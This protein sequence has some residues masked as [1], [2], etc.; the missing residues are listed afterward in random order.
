MPSPS[1][2]K[3]IAVVEWNWTGHHPAYFNNFVL[4]LEELGFD[5]LAICPDLT[6]LAGNI[7]SNPGTDMACHGKTQYKQIAISSATF[8]L[9][10]S[11]GI[12][13]I[14]WT[15]RFFR[16]IEQQVREWT[17]ESGRTVA[18]IFYCCMYDWEFAWAHLAQPFLT[19]PW[20]G[21]YL[22]A[23][24]YRMPNTVNP[25][26]R[27]VPR[28]EIMFGG[29]LCKG[30]AILDEGICKEVSHSTGKPVVAL[31]DVTDERLVVNSEGKRLGEQL[32]SFAAGRPVVGLFGHLGSSK[33]VRTFLAG[34]KIADPSKVCFALG[35]EKG[36]SGEEDREVK[37]LLDESP[38]VW[39]HLNRISDAHLNH[40]M[41][42]CQ[43][44]YAAYL[45]FPHSSNIMTKA[46]LL[47][48]PLVV[49]D[50]YLMAERTRRFNLGEIIPQ[51]NCEAFLGAIEKITKDLDAWTA[52][53]KPRW[54]DYRCEH[55]FARL[56][57]SLKE[58]FDHVR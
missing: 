37:R 14:Y 42:K 8:R 38:N 47:E 16:S 49:S 20:T 44:V 6:E 2:K 52:R 3:T 9:N 27:K 18:G 43:V 46:A 28:P 55:S 26:T 33:G 13:T 5:V 19:I 22:Q 35:G 31:P 58:L 48:K 1:A 15:V 30:I 17:R 41:S 4:A 10:R 50:G 29:R 23:R 34:A 32:E 53:N 11:G 39:C 40:L 12:H 56:K 25:V 57:I 7:R 21:L 45:D 36:W 51:G 24:T 54:A